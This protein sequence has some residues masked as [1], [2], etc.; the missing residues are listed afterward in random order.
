MFRLYVV[1]S[2]M[3]ISE[4]HLCTIV[5]DLWHYRRLVNT[6]PLTQLGLWNCSVVSLAWC[7]TA[8][9]ALACREL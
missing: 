1:Y 5:E 6:C 4:G 8:K 9:A 7:F 3:K 2:D